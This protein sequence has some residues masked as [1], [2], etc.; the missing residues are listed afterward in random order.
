M[1]RACSP[2]DIASK[3]YDGRMLDQFDALVADKGFPWK[4]RDLLPKVLVAGEDAGCLTKTGAGLLD[5]EG[6]LNAGIPMCPPEGDA[7][8]A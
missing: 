6:N 4:I 3:D 8:P 7:G 2:M 5:P 1:R